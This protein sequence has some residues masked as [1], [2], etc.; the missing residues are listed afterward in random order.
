M[1]IWRASITWSPVILRLTLWI[2]L[3][4]MQDVIKE[5]KA[6]GDAILTWRWWN[7]VIFILGALAEGIMV[8]R[9]YLDNSLSDHKQ[10]IE[11]NEKNSDG[12]AV[13]SS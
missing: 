12:S 9:I 4:I 3:A 8:W 1:K 13:T 5:L 6:A 2:L 7:W 11:Q 10:K